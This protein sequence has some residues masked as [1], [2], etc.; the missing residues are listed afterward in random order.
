MNSRRLHSITSSAGQELD[1][2]LEAKRLGGLE[3]DHELEFCRSLTG[4][5]LASRPLRIR[6]TYIPARRN[7]SASLLP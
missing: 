1:R 5:R 6:P 3:V 4:G 2:H 7:M